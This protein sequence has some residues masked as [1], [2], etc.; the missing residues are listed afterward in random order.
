VVGEDLE[1][2]TK[3]VVAPFFDGGGYGEHF[4]GVSGSFLEVRWQFL[5][6]VGNGV[7]GL[8]K[9]GSNGRRGGIIS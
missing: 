1:Q 9:H 5:A 4:A 6:E 7:D 3:E 8:G 2:T